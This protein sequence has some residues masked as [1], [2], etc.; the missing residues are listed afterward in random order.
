MKQVP[1]QW[2]NENGYL[3]AG[4]MK[5]GVLDVVVCAIL[6]ADRETGDV[7]RRTNRCHVSHLVTAYLL[8]TAERTG[9]STFDTQH[10]SLLT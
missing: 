2:G 5:F 10:T 6:S 7:F 9:L 4:R 8:L 3:G 1:F